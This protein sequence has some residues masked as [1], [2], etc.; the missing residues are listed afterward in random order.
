MFRCSGNNQNAD[1]DAPF[2]QFDTITLGQAEFV[3]ASRLEIMHHE[4]DRTSLRVACP[5]LCHLGAR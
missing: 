2:Y 3:G 4:Q 1:A 5:I